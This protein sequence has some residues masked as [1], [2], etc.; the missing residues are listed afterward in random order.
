MGKGRDHPNFDTI[1]AIVDEYSALDYKKAK[2]I[3]RRDADKTPQFEQDRSNCWLYSMF[4]NAYFTL[5]YKL[6]LGEI[7][8]IKNEMQGLGMDINEWGGAVLSGAFIAKYL[9]KK[10][11]KKIRCFRIDALK[12]AR[13]FAQMAHTLGYVFEFAR[14]DSPQFYED[15]DAD[16][17]VDQVHH[18]EQATGYHSTNVRYDG[19][20]LRF[21]ELGSWWSSRYNRFFYDMKQFVAN[22]KV[23]SFSPIFEFF[24]ELKE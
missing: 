4:N 7:I 14:M 18:K 22:I 2:L 8:D 23:W 16:G 13:D 15:L 10:L 11:N 9:S 19:A 1:M 24:A 3:D 17:I 5:G 20:S 6:S 12:E 21:E